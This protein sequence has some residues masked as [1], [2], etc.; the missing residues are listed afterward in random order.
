MSVLGPARL[1]GDDGTGSGRRPL[2][3]DTYRHGPCCTYVAFP[4]RGR[5]RPPRGQWLGR[6]NG[7]GRRYGL[8]L[9]L[10][11]AGGLFPRG[12][13]CP[14]LGQ[15]LG[16]VIGAGRRNALRSL[17]VDAGDSSLAG[18]LARFPDRGWAVSS[19]RVSGP[20][21]APH[22]WYPAGPADLAV[23]GRGRQLHRVHGPLAANDDPLSPCSAGVRFLPA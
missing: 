9:F 23:T 3:A 18:R 8:R 21:S 16:R 14:P 15:W 20:V 11:D 4:P 12:A 10:A 17:P 2:R 5:A 19:A 22:T 6:V 13:N 1:Y 7:A